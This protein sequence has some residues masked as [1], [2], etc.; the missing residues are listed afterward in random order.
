MSFTPHFV[1]PRNV[2]KTSREAGPALTSTLGIEE[3]LEAGDS[4]GEVENAAHGVGLKEG[5]RPCSHTCE[6]KSTCA[7]GKSVSEAAGRDV[8]EL[9]ALPGDSAPPCPCWCSCLLQGGR[10][11]QEG[12]KQSVRLDPTRPQDTAEAE[13]CTKPPWVASWQ[14]NTPKNPTSQRGEGFSPCFFG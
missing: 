2:E 14:G 12:E 5:Y 3:L 4:G 11:D 6:D 8:Q 9:A 10:T 7:H 1:G 13:P